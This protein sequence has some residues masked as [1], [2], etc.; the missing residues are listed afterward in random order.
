MSFAENFTK[1][2][3]GLKDCLIIGSCEMNCN[4]W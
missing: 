3:K 1:S 2:A 4:C